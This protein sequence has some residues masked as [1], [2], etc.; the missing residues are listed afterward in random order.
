MALY[1]SQESKLS[2]QE[3]KPL[4]IQRI[5][6]MKEEVS[7]ATMLLESNAEVMTA[8]RGYYVKLLENEDFPLRIDCRRDVGRF[9]AD[10]ESNIVWIKMQARRLGLLAEVINDR[11]NLVRPILIRVGITSLTI[12]GG[13]ALPKSGRRQDRTVES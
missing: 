6:L 1:G 13:S 11:K 2:R 8:L 10:M 12:A 7:Q 9:A 4:D 5:Q 3:Y